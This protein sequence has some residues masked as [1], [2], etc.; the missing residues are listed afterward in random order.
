MLMN[1]AEIIYLEVD[2]EITEAIDKLKSAK[3]DAVKV[4]VPARSSLLQS[5]VNL[6]LLKK[7]A[8]DHKKEL[9]LVTNDKTATYLAGGIGLA[10]AASLKAEPKVPEAIEEAIRP[11]IVEQVPEEAASEASGSNKSSSSSKG[12]K[13]SGSKKPSDE[14]VVKKREVGEEAALGVEDLAENKSKAKVPNY[15]AFQKKLWI[16]IGI[17]MGIV[18]AVILAITLPTATLTVLAKADKLGLNSDFIV[19]T[20][21]VATNTDSLTFAGTKLTLQK[22]LAQNFT[23][24]GKK[25]VGTK[26][27][28][29]VTISNCSKSKAF[30]I[31]AGTVLSSQGKNFSLNAA[32]SVP[33]AEF[34]NGACSQAGTAPGNITAGANGD[35]YNL[36]TTSFTIVGYD[37]KVSAKGSTSGGTSKTVT[38]VTQADIDGAKQQAIDAAANESKDE[39]LAKADKKDVV[40]EDTFATTTDSVSSSVPVDTEASNGTVTV[41]A[42][43][44]V[45]TASESTVNQLLDTLAKDAL[46]DGDQQLYQ[47]GADNAKYTLLRAVSDTRYQLNVSADAYYGKK[48]DTE[49]IAKDTAGKSKKD[50]TSIVQ[51]DNPSVVSTQVDSTPSL[52]PNMPALSSHIKVIIKVSTD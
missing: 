36:G 5:A 40:F 9:A 50:V 37:A 30:S 43:Y 28:G 45:V 20:S 19:D 12:G 47:N 11:D 10:V 14:G 24:T 6:K 29:G 26:A 32:V 25:D 2:A 23:A 15:N 49:Q 38:V 16:G 1:D 3:G 52:F 22:D 18:L 39:L 21:G 7:A 8:K 13:D 42:T 35:S 33:G 46:P 27:T 51:K 41:K 48:I 44:S 34:D 4:V 31:P 17:F